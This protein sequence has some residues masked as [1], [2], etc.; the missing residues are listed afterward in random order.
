MEWVW[1]TGAILVEVASTLA[2]RVASAG[3]RRWYAGVVVGYAASLGFLSLALSAGMGIGVAYSVWT[4]AGVGLTAILGRLFFNEPPALLFPDE[5]M[6]QLIGDARTEEYAAYLRKLKSIFAGRTS[7]S[8]IDL[9][10]Y[11]SVINRDLADGSVSVHAD[12]RAYK[13]LNWMSP[14][15]TLAVMEPDAD[16]AEA[17][18]RVHHEVG[19][20]AFKRVGR[21]G[22]ARH[23]RWPRHN[24]RHDRTAILADEIR[25]GRMLDR[26]CAGRTQPDRAVDRR[27][28]LS[29]AQL[30]AR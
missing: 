2:L 28:Q 3:R 11:A 29:G 8:R 5:I 17:G 15:C 19:R 20:E 23:C 25:A 4:A 7:R 12:D 22:H 21:S 13:P 14:P 1:L 6:D 26:R 10:L 30:H 16:Q 9:V 24:G 18:Q 27:A